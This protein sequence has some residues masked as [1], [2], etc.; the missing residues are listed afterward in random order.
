M[1]HPALVFEVQTNPP[2]GAMS[3]CC[4]QATK[5]PREVSEAP[6]P[7]PAEVFIE[8]LFRLR[9]VTRASCVSG[10]VLGIIVHVTRHT[11]IVN[12][13]FSL[14]APAEGCPVAPGR[15]LLVRVRGRSHA[16][17]EEPQGA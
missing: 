10:D 3:R 2:H 14:A 7:K 5:K 8:S 15:I 12:G 4:V 6:N 13:G 17:P 1:D 16:K 9:P 11:S